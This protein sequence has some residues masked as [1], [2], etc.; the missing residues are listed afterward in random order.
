MSVIFEKRLCLKLS[1]LGH[2]IKKWYSSSISFKLQ[3][4]H[5]RISK[6]VLLNLPVYTYNGK[7]PILNCSKSD[8]DL[9][10]VT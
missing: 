6:G 5:Q 1:Y 10:F 7:I 9:L 3:H 4:V 8:L 2:F